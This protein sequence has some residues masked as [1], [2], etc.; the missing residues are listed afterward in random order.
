MKVASLVG[1][2]TCWS[3]VFAALSYPLFAA[4]YKEVGYVHKEI[5][6]LR[7][8]TRGQTTPVEEVQKALSKMLAACPSDTYLLIDQPGLELEDMQELITPGGS[9][10]WYELRKFASRSA[11]LFSFPRLDGPVS[12]D[13]IQ[14][15]LEKQ[16]R[17]KTIIADA[18]SDPMFEQYSDTR[19]RVIR[20]QLE[21]LPE[22]E[23][24]KEITLKANDELIQKALQQTPSP[25]FTIIYTSSTGEEFDPE[26]EEFSQSKYWDIFGDLVRMKRDP[27]NRDDWKQHQP[28]EKKT[29]VNTEPIKKVPSHAEKIALD[30]KMEK[31]QHAGEAE[32]YVT[33]DTIGLVLLSAVGL[34]VLL[35]VWRVVLQLTKYFSAADM[36]LSEGQKENIKK[37]PAKPVKED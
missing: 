34:G 19:P 10:L 12:L 5:D 9:V 7:K 18:K 24:E 22:D 29:T 30:K 25:F 15:N 2:C 11:T 37:K 6:A 4:T 8:D 3:S 36:R 28:R 33:K 21:E 32:L 35:A 20:L 31:R 16:C 13:R 14:R 27:R 1:L 17:T 23:M 26:D